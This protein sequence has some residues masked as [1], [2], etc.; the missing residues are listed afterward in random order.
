MLKDQ[1]IGCF[2]GWLDGGAIDVSA[3]FQTTYWEQNDSRCV[4]K[5]V[6]FGLGA[7]LW[8][9]DKWTKYMPYLE[10]CCIDNLEF[11]RRLF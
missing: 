4:T 3:S 9:D 5:R 1:S 8:K 10:D 7:L 11:S 2:I 6:A